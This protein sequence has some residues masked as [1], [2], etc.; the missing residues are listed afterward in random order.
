MAG[1]AYTVKDLIYYAGLMGGIIAAYLVL[2][3]FGLHP[4][5]RLL[6]GLGLGIGIGWLAVSAYERATG[7]DE[8]PR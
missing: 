3:P 5:L 7:G 6:I 8:G 2:Q 1:P 4:L